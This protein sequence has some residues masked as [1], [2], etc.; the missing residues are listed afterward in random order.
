[1]TRWVADGTSSHLIEVFCPSGQ[2]VQFL[3]V[4]FFLGSNS[5]NTNLLL[6]WLIPKI[7]G[8]L[9]E[10]PL[11]VDATCSEFK[12]LAQNINENSASDFSLDEKFYGCVR[13]KTPN[14]ISECN[15]HRFIKVANKTMC[16]PIRSLTEAK[17]YA[18]SSHM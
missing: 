15:V 16:C 12:K 11:D 5:F 3:N 17:G 7:F 8:K 13:P 1:M 9:E 18:T 4:L 14:S 2:C 6:G 10:E